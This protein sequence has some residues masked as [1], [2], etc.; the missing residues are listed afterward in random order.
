YLVEKHSLQTIP[1]ALLLKSP[2]GAEAW[3]GGDGGFLGVGDAIY[4]QADPRWRGSVSPRPQGDE[5]Q[6]LVGSREEVERSAGSWT[7]GGGKAVLLEGPEARRN[8]FLD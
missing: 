3:D 4:N 5:L 8:T 6:R 1:G 7:A 2:A